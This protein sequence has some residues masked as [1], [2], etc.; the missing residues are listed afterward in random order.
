MDHRQNS[1]RLPG[2]L[3]EIATSVD[4]NRRVSAIPLAQVYR[5]DKP[6]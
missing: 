5:Q 3:R 6:Y 4:P 1:R 2:R